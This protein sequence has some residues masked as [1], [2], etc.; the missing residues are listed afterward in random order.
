ML[1]P[2]GT[3]LDIEVV[4]IRGQ[5]SGGEERNECVR[6][7]FVISEIVNPTIEDVL[8]TRKRCIQQ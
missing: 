3:C 6:G 1:L 7:V 8:C 5:R 2:V 4:G